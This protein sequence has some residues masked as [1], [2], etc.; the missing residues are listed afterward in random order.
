MLACRAA[1]HA[2]YEAEHARDT[3]QQQNIATDDSCNAINQHRTSV[4]GGWDGSTADSAAVHT[5]TT[6]DTDGSTAGTLGEVGITAV[7]LPPTA[8]LHAGSSS[9]SHGPQDSFD[10]QEQALESATGPDHSGLTCHYC[11]Q[12]GHIQT[13]CSVLQADRA[14]PRC[15]KDFTLHRCHYC[16]KYGHV[17]YQC[18]DPGLNHHPELLGKP[19]PRDA[20]RN[21]FAAVPQSAGSAPI[22]PGVRDRDES[23]DH[24]QQH[25][26][27]HDPPARAAPAVECQQSVC[28]AG[29]ALLPLSLGPNRHDEVKDGIACIGNHAPSTSAVQEKQDGWNEDIPDAPFVAL[30]PKPCPSRRRLKMTSHSVW[31]DSS[32]SRGPPTAHF[33]EDRHPAFPPGIIQPA[34]AALPSPGPSV[35]PFDTSLGHQAFTGSFSKPSPRPRLQTQHSPAISQGNTRGLLPGTSFARSQLATRAECEPQHRPASIAPMPTWLQAQHAPISS[36]VS[37]AETAKRFLP[38]AHQRF[39]AP[40]SKSASGAS[41]VQNGAD[42]NRPA[43]NQLKPA[44]AAAKAARH[45]SE[46]CY[47]DVSS[48]PGS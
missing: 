30:P 9:T 20:R 6:W 5:T 10:R 38:A 12:L 44:R 34:V 41:A 47:D 35:E 40:G 16:G 32:H 37:D 48:S 26:Y 19:A 31:L 45:A 46:N 42:I 39:P 33:P 7:S 43:C 27:T 17:S 2:A 14:K 25:W 24:Y 29:S 1:N 23:S 21:R 4:R 13:N 22:N 8:I 15:K 3:K 28:G 36:R 11:H 18:M